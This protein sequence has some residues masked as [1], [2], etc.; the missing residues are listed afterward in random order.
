M[1]SRGRQDVEKR[2]EA[3]GHMWSIGHPESGEL[4]ETARKSPKKGNGEMISY[5]ETAR[6]DIGEAETMNS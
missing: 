1:H 6:E 3:E 5:V 4:T 2:A